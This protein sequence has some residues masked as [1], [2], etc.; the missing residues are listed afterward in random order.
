MQE[1]YKAMI[2]WMNLAP[3][4]PNEIRTALKYD[5]SEVDGMNVIW[6]PQGKKRIDDADVMLSDINRSFEDEQI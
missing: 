6:I 4:T 5:T 2:E 3:L 1:D